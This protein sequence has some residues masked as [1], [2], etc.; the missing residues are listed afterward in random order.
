MK[1]ILV[2]VALLAI[3]AT[4]CSL[5]APKTEPLVSPLSADVEPTQEDQ[6][7]RD[8]S[9][10]AQGVPTLIGSLVLR[11]KTVH[12]YVGHRYSI[13]DHEGNTIARLIDQHEF[14]A[15]HST[16]YGELGQMHADETVWAGR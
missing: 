15:V 13:E 10:K 1:A 2:C 16:L 7:G 11:N 5:I 8:N 12:V 4:A 9:M 3:V 6:S 14:R